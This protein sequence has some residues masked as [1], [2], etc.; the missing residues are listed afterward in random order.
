MNFD[1]HSEIKEK[2]QLHKGDFVH[3][4]KRIR[5]ADG[6]PI[7]LDVDNVSSKVASH[8]DVNQIKNSLYVFFEQHL[9]MDIAYSDFKIKAGSATAD[10]ARH[11][12]IQEGDPIL[13]IKH[14]TYTKKGIPFEYCQTYYRADKYSL[15]IRA[16]R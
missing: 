3:V 5:T 12:G 2:L 10:I 8:I 4:I 6:E 13:H 14:I 9:H 16:Y 11:L 1:V 7:A 15:S